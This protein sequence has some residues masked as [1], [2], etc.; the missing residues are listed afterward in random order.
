MS[1][2]VRANRQKSPSTN[3]QEVAFRRARAFCKET[4]RCAKQKLDQCGC[5]NSSLEF[6]VE[7]SESTAPPRRRLLEAYAGRYSGGFFRAAS[8]ARRHYLG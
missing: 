5:L 3:G 6:L 8:A 4:F 2:D 7:G 1:P